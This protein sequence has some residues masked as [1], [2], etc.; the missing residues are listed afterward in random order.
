[1]LREK[2]EFREMKRWGPRVRRTGAYYFRNKTNTN[3]DYRL[4]KKEQNPREVGVPCPRIEK[5]KWVINR[6]KFS[7][8]KSFIRG[9]L[10]CDG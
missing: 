7:N 9:S 3:S 10:Q 6:N 1:M 5:R 8:F 2:R 4:G